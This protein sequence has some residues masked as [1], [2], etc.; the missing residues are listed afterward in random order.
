MKR[1]LSILILVLLA[2]PFLFG[3]SASGGP[4]DPSPY[5]RWTRNIGTGP[6]FACGISDCV[7]SGPAS[8]PFDLNNVGDIADLTITMRLTYRTTAGDAGSFRLMLDAPGRMD[9][10][11]PRPGDMLLRTSA[12]GE[13]T[14]AVWNAN[15]VDLTKGYALSMS[16]TGGRGSGGPFKISTRNLL[17]VIEGTPN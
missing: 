4:A 5:E 2:A 6:S 17:V 11:D 7:R 16:V 1:T 8:I 9:D 14:T 15:D 3:T 13:S 12:I 10:R